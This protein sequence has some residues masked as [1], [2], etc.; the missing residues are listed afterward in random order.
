MSVIQ[1]TA[2]DADDPTYGNSARVVY[3]ILEGQPYFS[4]DAKTGTRGPLAPGQGEEF[5][6]WILGV[7]RNLA[8]VSSGVVR[9]SLADM[10]RETRENYTV[11]IQAKDM[12][13]QL[14]GLAGTARVDISL[15]DVNDNPPVFDQSETTGHSY[16]SSPDNLCHPSER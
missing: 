16:C 14:G 9:V 5:L 7:S 6:F 3:S 12:G 13:G 8:V 15:G 11:V 2:T 10:D 1:L 4:V